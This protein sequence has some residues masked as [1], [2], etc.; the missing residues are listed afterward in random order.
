VFAYVLQ[1]DIENEVEPDPPKIYHAGDSF[2][3]RPMQVHHLLRNLNQTD[4][5]KI[6]IFQNAGT[7]PSSVKPLLQ[8]RLTK[9]TDQQV[10]MITLVTPP[11]A[12]VPAAHQHPGPVFAYVLRGEIESQ[13]DPDPPKVY[14]AGDVFHEPPMHAH[15]VFRNLSTTEAAELVIFQVSEIGQPLAMSAN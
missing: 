13:V 15:R 9:I 14:R 5:A 11:G 3:E 8:E 12:S 10:S 6:L 4:P 7:L 2:R 1:G